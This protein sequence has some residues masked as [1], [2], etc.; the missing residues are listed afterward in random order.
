MFGAGFKACVYMHTHVVFPSS[1][2]ILV[3]QLED[4]KSNLERLQL[5]SKR[6]HGE[7]D[8]RCEA[9]KQELADLSS[10]KKRLE[11]LLKESEA[12]ETDLKTSLS[13]RTQE[14]ASTTAEVAQVCAQP[15]PIFFLF[16]Y[17]PESRKF[18]NWKDVALR[19]LCKSVGTFF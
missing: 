18:P 1:F 19:N 11:R 4:S 8:D 9:L 7:L 17:D 6:R 14:V 16:R 5:E 15:C 13:Q 3:S 12:R 2:N 10:S